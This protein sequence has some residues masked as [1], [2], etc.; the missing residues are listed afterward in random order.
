MLNIH[1]RDKPYWMAVRRQEFRRKCSS[2]VGIQMHTMGMSIDDAINFFMKEGYQSRTSA[3]M[4]TMRGTSD[5][6]YMIYTLGKLAILK[7]RDDY[8]KKMGDKFT[9]KDFHDSLM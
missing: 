6:T 8:K 4:E 3:E 5:P 9:L 7:L 1:R 2:I